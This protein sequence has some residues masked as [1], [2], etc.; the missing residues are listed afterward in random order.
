MIN[1]LDNGN[2]HAKE[3]DIMANGNEKTEPT[4]RASCAALPAR[5]RGK[6]SSMLLLEADSCSRKITKVYTTHFY[7]YILLL[8]K[9]ATPIIKSKQSLPV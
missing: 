8:T 7:I 3:I 4:N 2:E 1:L 9:H 6:L 5:S